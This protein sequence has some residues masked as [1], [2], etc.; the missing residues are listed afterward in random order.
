MGGQG[1]G[2]AAAKERGCPISVDAGSLLSGAAASSVQALP[3]TPAAARCP[4][5]NG[6]GSYP[7][8]EKGLRKQCVVALNV[9]L[10]R[11][12]GEILDSVTG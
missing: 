2:R 10:S 8:L 12:N 4:T 1:Q 3:A 6:G 9:S 11:S 7:L 5:G